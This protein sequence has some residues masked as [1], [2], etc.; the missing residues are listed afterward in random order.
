[1]QGKCNRKPQAFSAAVYHVAE[2][3]IRKFGLPTRWGKAFWLFEAGFAAGFGGLIMIN[4]KL[5]LSTAAAIG[6]ILG[7]GAASAADF[8]VPYTKAPAYAPINPVINWAGFYIGANAGGLWAH[9]DVTDVNGYAAFALPGTVTP[10]NTSGFLA[11]GQAGY[12]WQASNYVFGLEADGGYMDIG[13]NTLLTGTASG[14]RV[15][16]RSGAYGDFTGRLGITW[17]RALFY[18]KGGYAIIDNASTFSTVTGSFS[19]SRMHSTD[20]GYTIGGGVEYKFAPNW[21]AK[22]EYLHFDFGNTLGY[23][24]FNAFGFPA[25]FNQNLRIETVKLGVNYTFDGPIIARY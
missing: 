12:N 5:V 1:M 16:L 11:G 19:G 13:G 22:V 3:S 20:S 4:S 2:P 18:V 9:S 17:N 10:V 21:S 7:V 24:V 23:T 8:G 25:A 14:T 15:G 6:A